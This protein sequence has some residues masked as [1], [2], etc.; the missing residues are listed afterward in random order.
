MEIDI[1]KYSTSRGITSKSGCRKNK[2]GT[3]K[4]IAVIIPGQF[5]TDIQLEWQTV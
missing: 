1:T 4:T 5:C 2:F 3:R